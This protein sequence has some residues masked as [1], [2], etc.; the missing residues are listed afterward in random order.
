METKEIILS[1]LRMHPI[2]AFQTFVDYEG[3]SI[4]S[5][6]SIQIYAPTT[7]TEEAALNGSMK[8]YKTFWN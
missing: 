1:F 7:N 4:S 6:H 5:N 8:T 3:Y 2:T